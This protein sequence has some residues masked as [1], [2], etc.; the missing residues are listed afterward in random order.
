M[1]VYNTTLSNIYISRKEIETSLNKL[2]STLDPGPD[3]IHGIFVKNFLDSLIEPLFYL[4]N[5]SLRQSL[6][7][8]IWKTSYVIPAHKKGDRKDI[9]NYRPLIRLCVMAKTFDSIM[10]VN[11][12]WHLQPFLVDE[13]RGFIR[14]RSITPNLCTYNKYIISALSEAYQ[15]VAI[16]TDL[17]SAFDSISHDFLLRSLESFGVMF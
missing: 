11:L 15:V 1:R 12:R 5:M 7:P 6:F 9:I 17:S 2:S 13:Q 3:G 4:F 10:E 8:E 16:Y 14:K